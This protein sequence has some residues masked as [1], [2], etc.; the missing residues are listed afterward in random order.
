VT[1]KEKH[2]KELLTRL[3]RVEGQV[4]GIQ[5]MIES[6][7]DCEAIAQQLSAARKALD[8]AFFEMVACSLEQQLDTSPNMASARSAT[9]Q[10]AK[11][12][13]KFG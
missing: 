8:R 5:G 4:R 7:A 3:R 11:M 6:E 1:N 9:A 12:L 10:M 13:S 2:Q